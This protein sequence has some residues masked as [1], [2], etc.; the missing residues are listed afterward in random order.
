MNFFFLLLMLPS[1][2]VGY[3]CPH[4]KP[5][6]ESPVWMDEASLKEIN[7]DRHPQTPARHTVNLDLPP[8]ERWVDI[9]KTYKDKSDLI[10]QY[11]E[12]MLP[13]YAVVAIDK[14]AKHLVGY[15]GF[16]DFG[17]EMIGY[18]EALELDLGYVVAAN[19]VYQLE[20]IGVNCSNWNNTGPTGQCPGEDDVGYTGEEVAWLQSDHYLKGLSDIVQTGYCT[21]VVT[22]EAGGGILH[23]RNLD[24][25]LDEELREFIITVDFER[26][27]EVLY[28]GSTIVSFVGILNAMA[29]GENGFSF[30]MDAR[31][32]GGKLLVNLVEALA[33]GA[34]TPCQHSRYVMETATDFDSAV[35]LFETG[36]L[37][38]DGYFIVGGAKDGEGAVVSRDRNRNVDTWMIDPADSERGWYRLETNYDHW[39]EVP[40]ADD[41][42]T[43]GYANMEAIGKD[44]INKDNLLNDVMTEWPTYNPHTDLT[45]IM[46]AK[47]NLYDCMIWLDAEE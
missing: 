2:A 9:G 45:C 28:T 29:P 41:R 25:N 12:S 19:L 3:Q 36:N 11:F 46:S 43:P 23:G 4:G 15:S 42:R 39:E 8:K 24:W 18:A 26:G 44:D 38:D 1:I 5:L 6:S 35:A 31:C 20:S 17:D 34:M 32:Q 33:K 47:Y 13:H 21:S 27:G 16:G 30:S 40:S 10:I 37:I 7:D 22:E 14:I